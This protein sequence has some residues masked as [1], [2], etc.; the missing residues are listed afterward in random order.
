M[1]KKIDF[2]EAMKLADI[3]NVLL[4]R[5]NNGILLSDY[6]ISILQRNG[7]IY[8]KYNDIKTLLFDI[9]EIL[10]DDYDDELDLISCQLAE[11]SY[12]KDTKKWEYFLIFIFLSF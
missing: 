6:Q 10:N 4:K 3:D 2:Y 7:I 1:S 12:Y 8:D 11:F 9:E 5:R